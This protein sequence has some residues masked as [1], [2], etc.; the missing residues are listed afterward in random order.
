M[1]EENTT[2]IKDVESISHIVKFKVATIFLNQRLRHLTSIRLYQ[3]NAINTSR[4][5]IFLDYSELFCVLL[6]VN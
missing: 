3:I 6:G 4:N 1:T 2:N 5:P